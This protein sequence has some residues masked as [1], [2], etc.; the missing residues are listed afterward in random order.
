[1]HSVRVGGNVESIAHRIAAA[2]I[3]QDAGLTAHAGR[4]LKDAIGGAAARGVVQ[5]AINVGLV[6]QFLDMRDSKLCPTVAGIA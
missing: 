1:M 3:D 5:V 2:G 6:T 4:G